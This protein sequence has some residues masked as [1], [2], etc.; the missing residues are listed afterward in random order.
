MILTDKAKEDFEKWFVE[1]VFL[2]Q[3][4]WDGIT[5]P[6]EHFNESHTSMQYGVYVD[7][8]DSVGMDIEI[9]VTVAGHEYYFMIDDDSDNPIMNETRHEART[10]AIE[11]ANEIYN[12][13][14]RLKQYVK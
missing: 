8:F 14:Q 12:K 5:A 10:K 6:V 4:M 11:K 3:F 9:C 1:S 2:N 7:W 13:K